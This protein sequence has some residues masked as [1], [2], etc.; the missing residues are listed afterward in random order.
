MSTSKH[1]AVRSNSKAS[2]PVTMKSSDQG[3]GHWGDEVKLIIACATGEIIL[4]QAANQG[5]VSLVS[6]EYIAKPCAF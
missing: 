6:I 3:I 1:D 5:V 2:N 4:T